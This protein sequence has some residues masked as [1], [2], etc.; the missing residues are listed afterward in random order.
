[1]DHSPLFPSFLLLHTQGLDYI[2]R[3]DDIQDTLYVKRKGSSV[4]LKSFGL[5]SLFFVYQMQSIIQYY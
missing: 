2:K 4:A 1:M 3:I 5:F